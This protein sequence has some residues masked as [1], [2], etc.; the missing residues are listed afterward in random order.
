[1]RLCC[2]RRK[3]FIKRRVATL[4][5]LVTIDSVFLHHPSW[6]RASD[7]CSESERVFTLNH[8]INK[9]ARKSSTF[10]WCSTFSSS[11]VPADA[12][13]NDSCHP[14]RSSSRLS[15]LS[16]SQVI[17]WSTQVWPW[18]SPIMR[19]EELVLHRLRARHAL[20]THLMN[21]KYTL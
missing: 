4:E 7:W 14:S 13:E 18:I 16:L 6:Q 21:P 17:M 5:G 2:L 10:V 12:E 9:H 20:P 3:Y 11:L 19:R 8:L 1:M 15:V